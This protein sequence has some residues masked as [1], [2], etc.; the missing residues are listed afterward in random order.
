MPHQC[1][2]TRLQVDWVTGTAVTDSGVEALG[3]APDWSEKNHA[4][5]VEL[6]IN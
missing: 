3:L 6:V 4:L 5:S 2:L 1:S